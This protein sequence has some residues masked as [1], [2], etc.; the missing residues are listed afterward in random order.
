LND[1]LVG[2]STGCLED[3]RGDWPALIETARKLSSAVVELSALSA[4]ELPGLIAHLAGATDLGIARVVVHAPTKHWTRSP[5]ELAAV[6]A[7]L[8]GVVD[9]IVV[10][11]EKLGQ[12]EAFGDVGSRLLLENMDPRKTDGRRVDELDRYFRALPTAG[13]CFDIA[14]AQLC[15]PSLKLAH[16]LLDA[17]GHRLAEVHLSSIT[18]EGIHVRL[19]D[20][21][22]QAFRR[23]LR[24]CIGVPWI[25]EAGPEMALHHKA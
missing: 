3:Q 11:P 5:P 7:G 21:D 24:R 22:A 9:A 14:H 12:P 10:H 23:V 19:R 25:L 16:A 6:L 4:R 2:V 18:A 8:P 1:G 20:A 13:F 17:F 15:D